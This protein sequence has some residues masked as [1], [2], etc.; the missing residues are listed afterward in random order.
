MKR[1]ITDRDVAVYG[2]ILNS[3]LFL[4]MNLILSK[5]IKN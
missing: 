4:F 2:M 5:L 3:S 1:P